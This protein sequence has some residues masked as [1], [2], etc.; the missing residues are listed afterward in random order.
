M[1]IS[2][3]WRIGLNLNKTRGLLFSYSSL[4]FYSIPVVY[5]F[6]QGLLIAL[7]GIEMMQ[8][9]GISVF[10]KTLIMKLLAKFHID[11][12]K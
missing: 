2:C 10:D 5:G 1:T 4:D 8:I 12:I 3:N 9:S 6:R 7:G 11:C